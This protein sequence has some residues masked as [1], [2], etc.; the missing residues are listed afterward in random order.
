M[1]LIAKE[2]EDPERDCKRFDPGKEKR[3]VE[4]RQKDR[5]NRFTIRYIDR[6]DNTQVQNKTRAQIWAWK[7]SFSP[8][9]DRPTNRPTNQ[10]TDQP[11]N[12]TT[13]GHEGSQGSYTLNMW[14]LADP[15]TTET[16]VIC[17]FLLSICRKIKLAKSCIRRQKYKS[18]DHQYLRSILKLSPKL[19]GAISFGI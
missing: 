3:I 11:T 9:F 15:V 7:C 5:L 19:L 12:Q 16:T 1:E 17:D 10:P 6:S 4:R 8:F 2:L 14:I 18:K 13:E